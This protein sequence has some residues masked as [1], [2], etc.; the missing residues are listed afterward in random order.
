MHRRPTEWRAFG[1]GFVP[2]SQID[3]VD[4]GDRE[5]RSIR[6]FRS[7]VQQVLQQSTI[8]HDDGQG[9]V[10]G[11][12]AFSDTTLVAHDYLDVPIRRY[13][14]VD[15]GTYPVE[16]YGSHYGPE[17]TNLSP[18]PSTKAGLGLEVR[19]W[20]VAS[21]L[22]PGGLY[23][24]DPWNNISYHGSEGKIEEAPREPRTYKPFVLRGKFLVILFLTL[25]ILVALA[26]VAIQLLPHNS[27]TT[28]PPQGNEN[29]TEIRRRY[30]FTNGIDL[31]GP[32]TF[33]KRQHNP[34][35]D[36]E[37]L[38]TASSASSSSEAVTNTMTATEDVTTA[39]TPSTMPQATSITPSE[40][41]PLSTSLTS[42]ATSSLTLPPS[43][44]QTSITSPPSSFLTT[45]SLQAEPSTPSSSVLQTP[46]TTSDDETPPAVTSPE[47]SPQPPYTPPP[48]SISVPISFPG[49]EEPSS[50]YDNSYSS[51]SS[52]LTTSSVLSSTDGITTSQAGNPGPL[53]T[54]D[55]PGDPT[56]FTSSTE[57][58]VALP[59]NTDAT[60]PP[61]TPTSPPS[62]FPSGPNGPGPDSSSSSDTGPPSPLPT[63][64]DS[65]SINPTVTSPTQ[66]PP[67]LS[68]PSA[69]IP[70]SPTTAVTS[71]VSIPFSSSMTTID[72]PSITTSP[73]S[74]SY[75]TDS[76]I[77]NTN[78]PGN[79]P[80]PTLP[81]SS[82]ESVTSTVEAP[83]SSSTSISSS[84][85]VNITPSTTDDV[86]EIISPSHSE[87]Y[88]ETSPTSNTITTT[89]LSQTNQPSSGSSEPFAPSTNFLD[90]QATLPP[91]TTTIVT[92]VTQ[93]D[94]VF[95][96]TTFVSV[97][98][99]IKAGIDD[100]VT[101][102]LNVY[103]DSN[104]R[105]TT[106]TVLGQVSRTIITYTDADGKPTSTQ[107]SVLLSLPMQTTLLDYQGRATK[108]E[109][110]FLEKYIETLYD[111]DHHPTA[112]IIA[113]ITEIISLI[114]LTDSNGLPTK[115]ITDLIP[116][117]PT[118][119]T[120]TKVVKPS[121]TAS[122]ISEGN[123]SLH[124]N[125]I[126][127]GKYFLGLMFPTFIAIAV[128]IPIRILDQTAKLY[129]PF[130]ALASGGQ[131]RDTL[132]F[133]TTGI[134]NFTERIRSLLNG[135][136]LLT[137]T[138]LLVLG[139]MIMIPLSSEAVR[140]ILEGPDCTGAK[141]DTL[142]CTM[143]VGIYSV[144]AQI[145]VALL[146]F[147]AV[148][149]GLI[150]M[151]LRNWNT[152]LDLNPWSLYHM[153]RLAANNEVRTL[154]QRRL[155]EKNGRI[156]HKQAEKA[157]GETPFILDYWRDNETLM[158]SILIPNEAQSLK[159][160]GRSVAF[161]KGKASPK[162]RKGDVIPFFILTW[163]GR[164]LFLLLLCAVMI[165]LLIYTITGDGKACTQFMMGKWRVVRFVF[166]CIGVLILLIWGSFFYAVAFL[167]PHKLFHRIRLYNGDAVHMTPP[168]N[169]FCGLKS[170]LTP[171]RRDIY[172]GLV[173]AI[174]ILSEILP[175]LLSTAL[176]K[177]TD[178]LWPH[179]VCLWMAVGILSI[180]MLTVTGSFF[181]SWPH[182]PIDPSTVAGGMYYALTKYM[183][184]SPSSGL[185]FGRASPG[186]V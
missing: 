96:E 147:M 150:I 177:C 141:G 21:D 139:S 73:P 14:E 154:L 38:A 20:P 169:P 45:T 102:Y 11:S 162:K 24:D 172:L 164:L 108:T 47:D 5:R 95:I 4:E 85:M 116:L 125:P 120:T 119:L 128:S 55:H 176:Y 121:S 134:W 78:P 99:P 59:T 179:T 181:V 87:P 98:H 123:K 79:G 77:T 163:T 157:L 37:S 3:D 54:S 168:S 109:S 62:S 25:A 84:T 65:T 175:V 94:G 104:G 118:S 72:S 69:P 8:T 117:T 93:S 7:R 151:V 50:S 137:L 22:S 170:S 127:D 171:G 86:S 113:T 36:N 60:S 158:Y 46:D 136:I 39:S 57:S 63:D 19:S 10:R 166:T 132:L 44:T 107:T 18:T 131:A 140:I 28:T 71:S 75:S 160:N 49:H 173:S 23:V 156:T 152:G 149:V 74:S 35:H 26:E 165:G 66:P 185:L 91:I 81:G 183:P 67:P 51:D 155:R 184:M 92:S 70:D 138:G 41:P 126:S 178:H 144:P 146:V 31:S 58:S 174:T 111:K 68:T 27:G 89:S 112:T 9:S 80:S 135:Q 61:I 76:S 122:P 129:Q 180:M 130:H 82:V 88:S 12:P 103:T 1:D 2:V 133:Q 15:I 6:E 106:E 153:G 32:P 167:S 124:V 16:Y 42:Q 186:L 13:E 145:A 110:Y 105:L 34:N 143:A 48:V 114:T 97:I 142:T 56:T 40:I 159:N 83:S 52:A 30:I 148:L 29:T 64:S 17:A 101:D 161:G 90:E 43:Q 53:P 33:F 182:M 100:S 115:T